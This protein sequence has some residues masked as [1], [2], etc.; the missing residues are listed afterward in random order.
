MI[1]T[2]EEIEQFLKD[3]DAPERMKVTIR[4]AIDVCGSVDQL[5]TDW[6]T[7]EKEVHYASK[8]DPN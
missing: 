3:Y 2:L 6:D 4:S 1:K 8:V 5:Y 7:A